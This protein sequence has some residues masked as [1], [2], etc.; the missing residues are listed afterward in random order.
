MTTGSAFERERRIDRSPCGA[1]PLRGRRVL[2]VDDDP[3]VRRMASRVLGHAG[4]TC[5]LAT[6]QEQALS[7]VEREPSLDLVL[8]DFHMADG[9]VARL[10]DRLRD[11]L[12]SLILVGTSGS[13]C[14]DE[15]A[16][17]GVSRFLEK[18]WAIATLVR[19]LG[20]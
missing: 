12:T 11:R 13:D 4:A 3:F 8:L 10:V 6:T 2:F 19:E 18:P 7:I 17:R 5:L 15:F 1:T 20:W 16:R 14:R 9:D